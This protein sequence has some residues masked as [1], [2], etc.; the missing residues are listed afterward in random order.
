M[1]ADVPER[2]LIRDLVHRSAVL[3]K[4]R[5]EAGTVLFGKVKFIKEISGKQ[6]R[7]L[8]KSLD[9]NEARQLRGI[10]MLQGIFPEYATPWLR[11]SEELKIEYKVNKKKNIR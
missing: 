3:F 11:E 2:L 4:D 10:P 6:C 7:L 8:V 5:L 1:I 9:K